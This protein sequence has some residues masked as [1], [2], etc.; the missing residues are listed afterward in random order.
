MREYYYRDLE[1]LEKFITSGKKT[2]IITSDNLDEVKKIKSHRYGCVVL[3]N[4]VGDIEDIQKFL[5][6]I[7]KELGAD[8]RLII[9]YY[10][11][12]W[13]PVLKLASWLGIRK[14]VGEQ[15]WL[16]NEDMANLLNLAGFEVV[17][18]YKRLLIPVYIPLVS[19]LI[20][21]WIA[22]LPLINGLC[23]T[24]L[25]IARPKVETRRDYS[26]SIVI[27]A[28]NEE[29]NIVQILNRIPKFSKNM[30]VVFVEGHSQ[31]G[32]WEAIRQ[33]RDKSRQKTGAIKVRA[34]KQ[35]GI[36]KA[37]AVRLGL[38]KA[39]GELLIILDADLTVDPRDLPKFYEAIATGYGEFIN[40]S[41]LVYP[42]EKQA[43]QTLNKLA[44]QVFSWLFSWILGQHFKDTLC[45]TKALLKSNYTQIVKMRGIFG[46]ND[47]FGDFDL[48]FG[49][50]KQNLKVAEIPVRYHE[51]KYGRTNI[52]RFINGWMLLKMTWLAFRKFRA[53]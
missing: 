4:A 5:N 32:T 27:P 34:F 2:L 6:K 33:L 53:W 21:R 15:N 25:V 26:V 7:R 46:E 13:E 14:K 40:G 44:N 39:Q 49:A 17:A 20:N 22:P 8:K 11:H 24:S 48:I 50:I 41:R 51:R 52:S 19:D 31:D 38:A 3:E 23:L 30:E 16:D 35:S 12:L 1:L 29:G 47:P 43:M 42:M 9:I 28:R 18:K 37:D 36:G 10:N 45:G